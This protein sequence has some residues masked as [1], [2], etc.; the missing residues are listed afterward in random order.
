MVLLG[1]CRVPL[2]RGAGQGASHPAWVAQG[3]RQLG[4]LT[5]G[6]F[7]TAHYVQERIPRGSLFGW[8]FLWLDLDLGW[9]VCK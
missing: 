1:A 7:G 6:K 4:D 5:A 9:E 2:S 3:C 8:L